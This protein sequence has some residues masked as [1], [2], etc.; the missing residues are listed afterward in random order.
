[1]ASLAAL[2]HFCTL[3]CVIHG[4]LTRYYDRANVNNP[5]SPS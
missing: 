1:M 4:R 5:C 2:M 3:H